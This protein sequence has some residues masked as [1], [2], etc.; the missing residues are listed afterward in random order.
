MLSN[1][2]FS[3]CFPAAEGSRESQVMEA[4]VGGSV[5]SEQPEHPVQLECTHRAGELHDYS[6]I[7]LREAGSCGQ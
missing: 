5:H 7:E 4:A 2:Y 3:C 1:K 6:L